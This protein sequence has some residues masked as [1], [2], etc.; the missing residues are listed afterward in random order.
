M[1][2]HLAKDTAP[3][4]LQ[5]RQARLHDVRLLGALEVFAS[6]ADPLLGFEKQTC[7]LGPNLLGQE[8]QQGYAE[9]QVQLDFLFVLGASEGGLQQFERLAFPGAR[10]RAFWRSRSL[11]NRVIEVRRLPNELEQIEAR[12]FR[13]GRAQVDVMM[14]I[15][16][17]NR[18]RA[19]RKL[20]RVGLQLEAGKI[21]RERRLGRPFGRHM[22]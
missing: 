1:L 16:D 10:F 14:D 21:T 6:T 20:R 15:V 13:P 5:L 9:Q 22:S 19:Q 11:A 7:K 3:V 8:L 12:M 4:G 2:S 18:K 17:A